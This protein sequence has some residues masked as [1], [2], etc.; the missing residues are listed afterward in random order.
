MIVVETLDRL[1]TSAE[2]PWLDLAYGV[3]V[4]LRPFDPACDIAVQRAIAL[5]L[6]AGAVPDAAEAEGFIV[7]A[8]R[9]IMAWERVDGACTPENV[10]MV[11]RQVE[12]MLAKFRERYLFWCS[13]WSAEGN[14]SGPS[15]NGT[16][17]RGQP[18]AAAA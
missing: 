9:R 1:G 5:A 17:A 7:A 18:T 12:G 6:Q 14:G 3:R 10:E 4:Q 11:M 16:S 15:P 13:R 2:P 8:K